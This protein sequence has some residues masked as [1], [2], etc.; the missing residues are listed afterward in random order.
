MKRL[1]YVHYANIKSYTRT[2]IRLEHLIYKKHI[3]I[4]HYNLR[5]NSNIISNPSKTNLRF[6]FGFDLVIIKI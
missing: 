6:R 4:Y 5:S 2:C 1:R 3:Y